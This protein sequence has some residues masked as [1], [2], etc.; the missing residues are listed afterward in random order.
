M[1]DFEKIDKCRNIRVTRLFELGENELNIEVSLGTIAEEAEVL[2]IGNVNLG[3]AYAV[4]FDNSDEMYQLYF[5][6]YISYFV[7]KESY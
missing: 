5:D 4:N 6:T 7:V 1:T 3:P 2:T